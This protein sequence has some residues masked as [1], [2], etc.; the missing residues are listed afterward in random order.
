MSTDHATELSEAHEAV[1]VSMKALTPPLKEL[2]Q[3]LNDKAPT[4]FSKDDVLNIRVVSTAFSRQFARFQKAYN[5]YNLLIDGK[6]TA[7]E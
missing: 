3:Q 1:M 7:N 6:V 5:A 2:F 4:Q